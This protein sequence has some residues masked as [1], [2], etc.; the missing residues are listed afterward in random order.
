MVK[1]FLEKLFYRTTNLL[2]N[3]IKRLFS[4]NDSDALSSKGIDSNCSL[5]FW[6]IDS[7]MN[8]LIEEPLLDELSDDNSEI[9]LENCGMGVW[10]WEITTNIIFFSAESLKIIEL[11]SDDVFDDW[12]RWFKVVHPDDLEM[13]TSFI[14]KC[15]DTETTTYE[16][17]YRVL[18][19][20]GHYKWIIDKAKVIARDNDGKPLRLAGVHTDVYF[21]I[22][23]RNGEGKR[24]EILF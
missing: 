3:P 14:L 15:F 7:Y 8:D 12:D 2:F 13:Y 21:Q 23:K 16:H 10:H 20:S 19:N 6:L 18:T 24:G 9:A 17:C 5:S 11:E 4:K 1:I 22:E